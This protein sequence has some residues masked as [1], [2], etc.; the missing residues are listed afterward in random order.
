MAL[1]LTA[2]QGCSS[3]SM[4]LCVRKD[5]GFVLKRGRES[6]MK[7]P[8]KSVTEVGTGRMRF[9]LCKCDLIWMGLKSGEIQVLKGLE[10]PREH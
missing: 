8:E 5:R 7:D 2:T 10:K 1:V 9:S 6:Y 3:S 4:L